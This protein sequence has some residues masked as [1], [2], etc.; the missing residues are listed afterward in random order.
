MISSDDLAGCISRAQTAMGDCLHPDIS[1]ELKKEGLLI[2]Y[3]DLKIKSDK[4][5]EPS[6]TKYLLD[7]FAKDIRSKYIIK[8]GHDHFEE[9]LSH[10]ESKRGS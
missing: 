10:Y 4:I 2:C 8:F 6:P 9:D 3:H 1:D 7:R 5:K